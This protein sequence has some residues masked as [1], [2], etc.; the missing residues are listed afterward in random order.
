MSHSISRGLMP[1]ATLLLAATLTALTPSPAS[2]QAQAQAP[3]AVSVFAHAPGTATQ[4]DSIVAW[5]D[6]I[7]V[8]FENGVAKDGSDGKS[9]TIVEFSLS[10]D[11]LLS[12]RVT[13]HND[14]LRV[15]GDHELWALQNEDANPNL[16]VIDLESGTA[17]PYQFA[18]TPHGGGYDDIVVGADGAVYLTASNPNLNAQGVNVYPA[19]VRARV[20]NGNVLL[21]PVLYGNSN[22]T[23]IG[24]GAA[25]TLNL[26]D[27]DSMTRDLKGDIVFTSQADSVLVFVRHPGAADQIVGRLDISS[28]AM[29]PGGALVTIDDTAFTPA[30]AAYLLVTDIGGNTIY[31]IDRSGFGFEPGQA[32]SASDTAGIVGTLNLD[33]GIVT[34][35]VTGLVSARGLQFVGARAGHARD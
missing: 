15:V 16:V 1:A 8:G 21:E 9:S 17:T 19:L 5:R 6:R 22:A 28:T 32:Y 31:R 33:N 30:G 12:F 29:G 4:P 25:V 26:T 13:G 14:G 27:P 35:I 2:A 24:T 20:A 7:V 3:Y 10:G 34:P 23:D 11:P 18:P